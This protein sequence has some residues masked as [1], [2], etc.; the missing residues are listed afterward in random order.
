MMPP[1]ISTKKLQIRSFTNNTL[2]VL[3]TALLILTGCNKKF[4]DIF[5]R[6]TTLVV[7]DVD[8]QYLSSKAKI[9]YQAKDNFISATANIR[10]CKDSIIWIS[11]SPGLGI[12]A[13]RLLVTKD[14][15]L[16][17]DKINKTYFEY[18][19]ISLSKKLD[20]NLNYHLIESVIIGNLIY[21]YE[22]EKLMRK[23]STYAYGQS[24]GSFQFENYIGATSMKLE[25][26]HVLDTLSQNV[27]DYS[28]FQLVEEEIF[29][30]Q[31]NAVLNYAKEDQTKTLVDILF[32]Q[33]QIEEKPLKFPFNIPQRYDSK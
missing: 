25:K 27:V 16:M 18:D 4:S 8:F 30:F 1:K 2:I 31:I 20:F 14:S 26:I 10:I 28:D 17:I 11:L 3:A 22:K 12:E 5:D 23:T 9:D 24:Q 19:F 13:A 7:N 15:V 21:P 6:T 32:K 33:H 29:P